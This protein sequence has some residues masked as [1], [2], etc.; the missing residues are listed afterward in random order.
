MHVVAIFESHIHLICVHNNAEH[1]LY[2]IRGRAHKIP[3]Y[4]GKDT[5]NA[6]SL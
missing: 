1:M 3:F 6:V 5:G 4:S 2:L